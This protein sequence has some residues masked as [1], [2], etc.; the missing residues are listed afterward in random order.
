MFKNEQVSG[1]IAIAIYKVHNKFKNSLPISREKYILKMAKHIVLVV[2]TL[3][4]IV[5]LSNIE[6]LCPDDFKTRHNNIKYGF[7]LFFNIFGKNTY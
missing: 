7:H 4:I 6:N 1:I 3:L 5:R 2:S